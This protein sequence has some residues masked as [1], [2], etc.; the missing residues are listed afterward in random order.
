[1]AFNNSGL[2]FVIGSADYTLSSKIANVITKLKRRCI[3]TNKVERIANELKQPNRIVIIDI[4][5]KAAQEPGQ[6]R[7]LINLGRICDNKLICMCPNQDEKL[8]DLAK[9]SRPYKS[10]LRYDLEIAFKEEIEKL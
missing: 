3:R 2:L 1:M 4:N 5:W 6:L 7:R 9:K 8:K 10:F